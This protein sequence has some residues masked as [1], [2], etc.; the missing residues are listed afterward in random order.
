MR[1][2]MEGRIRAREAMAAGEGR[3]TR[4]L[5]AVRVLAERRLAKVPCYTATLR[6]CSWVSTLPMVSLM[7]LLDRLAQTH[8][9]RHVLYF[10]M[11][12]T[13]PA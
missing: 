13:G 5:P 8:Y 3:E 10:A 2:A 11:S 1:R 7:A 12:L 4:N 6:P 9:G